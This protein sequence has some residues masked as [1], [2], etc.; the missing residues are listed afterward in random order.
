[1]A[2]KRTHYRIYLDWLDEVRELL[3]RLPEETSAALREPVPNLCAELRTIADE[4]EDNAK[5]LRIIADAVQHIEY[6]LNKW[7]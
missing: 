2:T 5:Q 7:Q 1:M 4:L 6:Q 3:H